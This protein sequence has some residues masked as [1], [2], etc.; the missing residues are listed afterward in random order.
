MS[1]TRFAL[2]LRGENLILRVSDPVMFV[3]AKALATAGVPYIGPTFETMARCYD[4]LSA[5]RSIGTA[6]PTAGGAEAA[7]FN[8]P[9]VVKPRFGSDSIGVRVYHRPPL[10]HGRR[11]ADYI[12]Q[13]RIVG[14]E[15]TV[16]ILEGDAGA[17]LGIDMPAGAVYSFARKYVLRPGITPLEDARLAPRARAEALQIAAALGV[18]WAA[19]VD[20]I[21]EAATDRLY[22]LECDVAPLIGMGSAFEKSLTAC[23]MKRSQQLALLFG[24]R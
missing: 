9:V 11:T 23:G 24:L 15:L 21:H 13:P 12:V 22:F 8:F 18:D 10:P 16:A 1:E 19:R 20:F 5:S 4:K 17:P 7:G 14:R 6:P 2:D 3:A